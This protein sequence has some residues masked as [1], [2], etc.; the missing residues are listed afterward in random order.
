MKPKT[1]KRL[2]WPGE[3]KNYFGL[4]AGEYEI[5]DKE[6]AAYCL[7]WHDATP[8]PSVEEMLERMPYRIEIPE[9]YFYLEIEKYCHS[10]AVGYFH[11][12][13]KERTSASFEEKDNLSE[14][15]ALLSI[16][17]RDN[18]LMGWKP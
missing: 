11:E 7:G 2:A 9:G 18:N 10:Y 15:V 5:H 14:A 17:L 8:C 16:W 12:T 3:T 1:A 4:V 6:T 13:E